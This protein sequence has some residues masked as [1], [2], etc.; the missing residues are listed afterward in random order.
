MKIT[1][2][3]VPLPPISE[4]LNDTFPLRRTTSRRWK[5]PRP[6]SS[7][8]L[9]HCVCVSVDSP[10]TDTGAFARCAPRDQLLP[11][12]LL[13]SNNNKKNNNNNNTQ[14]ETARPLA[15][16]R[17]YTH[18]TRTPAPSPLSLSL[19]CSSFCPFVVVLSP[20]SLS[21][22]LSLLACSRCNAYKVAVPCVRSCSFIGIR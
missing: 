2:R 16:V 20:L 14:C 4:S 18:C 22:S 13:N 1:W 19:S 5:C 21:L 15:R 8:S 9:T 17:G 10:R 11:I 6:E 12:V 3:N 7:G